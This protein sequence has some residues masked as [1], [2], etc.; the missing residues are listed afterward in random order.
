[1]RKT[2]AIGSMV[3][4]LASCKKDKDQAGDQPTGDDV[5]AAKTKDDPAKPASKHKGVDPMA[6]P[7]AIALTP[8]ETAQ[9]AE[10]AKQGTSGVVQY[11]VPR[12]GFPEVADPILKANPKLLLALMQQPGREVQIAAGQ[13]YFDL[14]A[15][16]DPKLVPPPEGEPIVF[17]LMTSKDTAVAASVTQSAHGG[18]RGEQAD[19]E[20]Q[21]LLRRLCLDDTR[22]VVRA[23][24]CSGVVDQ[25]NAHFGSVPEAQAVA[26]Q[27]IGDDSDYVVFRT[28]DIVAS[29][30]WDAAH[31]DVLLPLLGHA[32]PAIRGKAAQ[33]VERT[34]HHKGN[35]VPEAVTKGHDAL[36]KL[37]K[38]K[39]PYVRCAAA[40]GLSAWAFNTRWDS[41]DAIMALADDKAVP[42]AKLAYQGEWLEGPKDD[43][44][45]VRPP[46]DSVGECAIHALVA[47][48]NN[49][50]GALAMNFTDW[51]NLV[52]AGR[53]AF[54]AW[55][56]AHK[57][58]L[59]APA[60]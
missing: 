58:E 49:A 44:W 21:Q 57:A 25:L 45:T 2:I 24:A 1:M 5:A 3:L 12:G 53:P 40:I 50:S 22:A 51:T 19:P 6:M 60:P 11:G 31:L 26:A 55:W 8:E 41:V 13:E 18:I 10:L 14:Q 38:D 37:L 43:T 39:E 46:R 15:Y 32:E 20:I 56:A 48:A 27:A 29:M 7:A 47:K 42:E 4:A 34:L 17:A 30:T 52:T 59:L 54:D 16:G 33:I 9:V 23:A 28:L 35:P 36:V